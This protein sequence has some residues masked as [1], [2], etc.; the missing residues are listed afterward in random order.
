LFAWDAL[1]VMSYSA[2]EDKMRTIL[3]M[4]TIKGEKKDLTAS[5]MGKTFSPST[6]SRRAM[7]LGAELILKEP[8]LVML[9]DETPFGDVTRPSASIMR[10]V[11]QHRQQIIGLLSVHSY[12]LK[13]YDDGDLSTLQIFADYCA[14]ALERMRVEEKNAV[15]HT[16]LLNAAR[17][18]GMEEVANNVLHNIGNVLTSV[19]VSATLVKDSLA[20][21][22]LDGLSRVAA[23]V[24]EHV[25][26]LGKF[27]TENP[28]GIQLPDYLQTLAEYRAAEQ[29]ATLKEL[30]AL[31]KNLLHVKNIIN[32]QQSLASAANFAQPVFVADLLEDALA[33]GAP[34]LQ[35]CGI[36]ISREYTVHFPALLDR[37]KLMLIL[38]NLV[39]NARDALVASA[40]G[41]KQLKV[42][43]E[44]QSPDRLRILI[45]DNGIGISPENLKRI[46]SHGFSTKKTG[47]GFGLHS[48][49]LT[50]QE[51]GGALTAG[52]EGLDK[53]ARFIVDLPLRST[54]TSAP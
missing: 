16:Q 54:K 32:R 24:K 40:A 30:E 39:S 4:D 36:N 12:T 43:T 34:D 9:S 10:V 20:K 14:G 53:G 37:L 19:N 3:T 27:V 51:L 28:Q 41:F 44:I 52:S 15:L 49:L 23:L 2:D 22:K 11:I 29:G 42:R 48:S 8:P 31:E 6:H 38:V 47:H 25:A 50:A 26:D 1:T 33:I 7:G 18:A 35:R 21:S 17:R 46:F 13:A 45:S 5:L